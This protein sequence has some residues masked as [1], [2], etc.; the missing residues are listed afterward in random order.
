MSVVRD[1]SASSPSMNK[2]AGRIKAANVKIVLAWGKTL[3]SKRKKPQ[4]RCENCT[5]TPE[6][7][8]GNPKFMLCSNCKSKL[9]FVV[10]YCSQ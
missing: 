1:L 8:G 4:I 3:S 10:Y 2:V 6:E 9:D 7:I 5:K